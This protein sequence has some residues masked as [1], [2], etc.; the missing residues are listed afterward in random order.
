MKSIKAKL[1]IPLTILGTLMC[2]YMIMMYLFMNENINHVQVLGDAVSTSSSEIDFSEDIAFIVF[3]SNQIK[4]FTLLAL[5]IVIAAYLIMLYTVKLCVLRPILLILAKLKQ[6][7]Q[8]SGDLTQSID[9][10]KNDEIG[11]LA[12]NF[13]KMQESFRALI[14]QVIEISDS[15]TAGMQQTKNNVDEGLSLVHAMNDKAMNISGDM[16]ENAASVQEATA[17]TADIDEKLSIMTKRT[18]QES[19]NSKLIRTRAK[20]LKESAIESKKR[21]E[22]INESTKQKLDKAMEDAKAVEKVNALTD[23]I[24]DI[25]NQTNLLALNASIEAARAGEAGKGFAVVA[26]E[27]N[28]LASDSAKS[29]EEIRSVNE[30]VLHI[31]QELVETLREVYQFIS[32]DVVHNYQETVDTGEQY[33]MD[34]ENFYLVTTEIART[35]EQ[36]LSNMDTLTSNMNVMADASG[37]SADSTIEISGNVTKLMKYFDEI[38]SLS[39]SLYEGTN[40]LKNLVSKYQV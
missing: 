39:D 21:A 40:H 11:A 35:S 9:Y 29:V 22:T 5:F 16:Q 24:M 17:I 37:R 14:Q 25:A 15:T 20:Q 13:N 36:L 12:D 18:E 27:I 1:L 38:S 10:T 28:N 34:A 33:D 23:T 30:N 19:E 7:A 32:E 8:N 26:S 2:I 31:V 4:N 6:M 3:R